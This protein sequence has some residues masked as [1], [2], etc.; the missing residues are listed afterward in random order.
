MFAVRGTRYVELTSQLQS[1]SAV[2]ERLNGW[3][4]NIKKGVRACAGLRRL[5]LEGSL[6]FSDS[7]LLELAL[8]QGLTH[9]DVSECPELSPGALSTLRQR[10]PITCAI[11]SATS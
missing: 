10:M 11:Y 4:H 2:G 9:L 7:T 8:L 1:P 3:W 5:N 6:N